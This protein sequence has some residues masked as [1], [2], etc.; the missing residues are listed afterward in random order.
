MCRLVLPIVYQSAVQLISVGYI[1]CLQALKT[2][3]QSLHS[4][5]QHLSGKHAS[6]QSDPQHLPAHQNSQPVH[7]FGPFANMNSYS[8][9]PQDE[10]YMPFALQQAFAG[11][12]TYHQSLGAT[13]PQYKNSVS[14][15][16]LPQPA[17]VSAGYGNFEDSM[18]NSGNYALNPSVVPAGSTIGYD[19]LL[20]TRYKDSSYSISP[21]QV[22]F[23]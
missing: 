18:I 22:I 15:S 19:D 3:L 7:P 13:L 17:T 10:T 6:E 14:L 21:Q 1:A 4:T 2:G 20:S 5:Q 12:G 9:V 23:K 16:S 11:N 8:Y